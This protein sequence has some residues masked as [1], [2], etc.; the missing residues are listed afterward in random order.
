MRSRT[1]EAWQ[2]LVGFVVVTLGVVPLVV[3]AFGA[4]TGGLWGLVL[5]GD[6]G[7]A[8]WIWPGLVVVAG[9]VTIGV[10]ERRKR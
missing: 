7:V 3:L 9:V 6:A 1:S 10:L 5:D 4:P 2:G 8:A